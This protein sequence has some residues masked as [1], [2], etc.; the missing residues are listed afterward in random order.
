MGG[1]EGGNM[2]KKKIGMGIERTVQRRLEGEAKGGMDGWMD[3]WREGW[4]DEWMNGWLDG[5]MDGWMD[6]WNC[7][8]DGQTKRWIRWMSGH[9]VCYPACKLRQ[10][11]GGSKWIWFVLICKL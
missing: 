1:K 8:M 2:G 3:G 10:K 4:M 6:I 5:W 7:Q 9:M 11:R